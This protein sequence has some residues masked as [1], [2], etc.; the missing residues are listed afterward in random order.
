M[1][2]DVVYTR[3]QQKNPDVQ[4]SRTKNRN[5]KNTYHEKQYKMPSEVEC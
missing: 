4:L 1:K 5:K 3:E 2:R